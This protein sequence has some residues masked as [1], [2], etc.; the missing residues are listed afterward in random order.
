MNL[1]LRVRLSL[2]VLLALTPFLGLIIYTDLT[3]RSEATE[4]IQKD[5]LALTEVAVIQE[6]QMLE[7]ARQLLIGMA[8]L[9]EVRSGD[10]PGCALQM[11]ELAAKLPSYA[12]LGAVALDGTVFCNSIEEVASG[13]NVADRVYFSDPVLTGE[14]SVGRYQI[15]RLTGTSGLGIGYPVLDS[16]GTLVS[17]VFAILDLGYLD[18]EVVSRLDLPA[19]GSYSLVDADGTILARNPNPELWIGQRIE[20]GEVIPEVLQDGSLSVERTGVDEVKR[21]YSSLSV[22]AEGKARLVATIGIDQT[23][24]LAVINADMRQ[25]LL[26]LAAVTLV[27]LT[28]TWFAS[29]WLVVNP[30]RRLV[31]IT[32]L[33]AGGDLSARTGVEGTG[34][35]INHLAGS[36]DVMAIAL[37]RRRT[38]QRHTAEELHQLN[39]TLE[40][41]VVDRTAELATVNEE[42]NH[43]NAE[44]DEFTHVVSHDL[45]EP[46]RGIA[47]FNALMLEEC[48]ELGET[49]KRYAGII[50]ESTVRMKRLIDDLL[51]LSRIGRVSGGQQTVLLSD[52]ASEVLDGVHY[53]LKEKGGS[54]EISFAIGEITADLTRLKQVLGN[55][56]SNAIKYGDPASPRITIRCVLDETGMFIFSVTDNGQGIE[57]RYHEKV[58]GAFQQLEGRNEAEGTGIG[59]TICRRIVEGWGGRIWVD[60]APGEGATFNFTMPVQILESA[61]DEKEVVI[62]QAA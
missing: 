25:S 37:L 52:L 61:T 56:I 9:P 2:L 50:N 32:D 21:L 4:D 36:I 41:R 47:G 35:E 28:A 23:A 30:T 7:G 44:L 55:L 40:Q 46:L 51:E 49:G 19:G 59:L 15:G 60:S 45:K 6:E 62:E 54:V 57:Q 20:F 53:S 10:A 39:V 22:N 24:A 27:A 43:R 8:A 31:Q 18:R 11:A 58:F 34:G 38:E 12:N 48:P 29:D 3:H 1:S 17:V 14:F 42:L 16:S 33:L 5:A 13:T 26:F